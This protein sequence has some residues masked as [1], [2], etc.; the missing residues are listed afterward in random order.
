MDSKVGTTWNCISSTCCSSDIEFRAPGFNCAKA[1]SVGA[2]IV[3]PSLKSLSWELIWSATW[4]LLNIRSRTVKSP[5]FSRIWM[6]SCLRV[7]DGDGGRGGGGEGG[8]AAF[9]GEGA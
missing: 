8:R 7:L 4:V 2:K 9:A 3:S 5:S 1:S 6:M